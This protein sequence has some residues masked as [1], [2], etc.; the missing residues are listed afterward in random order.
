MRKST[1]FFVLLIAFT[2]DAQNQ[3]GKLTVEKIMRDPKWIGTS[4]A[5]VSWSFDSKYIYFNWNPEK[6]ITD[7]LYYITK[8]NLVPQK[9]NYQQRQAILR[10]RDSTYNSN[11]SAYVYDKDGDI[12]MGDVKTGKERRIT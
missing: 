11:R 4:P 6:A 9:T 8:E 2:S 5:N 3:L 7:S 10:N 12:F 1:A